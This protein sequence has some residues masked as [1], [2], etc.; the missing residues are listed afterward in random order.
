[1]TGNRCR[2]TLANEIQGIPLLCFAI[3]RGGYAKRN[4]LQG[5]FCQGKFNLVTGFSLPDR[6]IYVE[7]LIFQFQCIY[8]E[9]RL[10]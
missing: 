9:F 3:L 10:L 7:L 5:N 2:A 1:M 4:L 6:T 8:K